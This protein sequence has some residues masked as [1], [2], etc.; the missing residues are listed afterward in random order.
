MFSNIPTVADQNFHKNT[1]VLYILSPRVI[2]E[3]VIRPYAYNFNENLIE[4]LKDQGELKQFFGPRSRGANKE[5]T[6]RAI[7]PSVQGT[8]VDTKDLSMMW[9]FILVLDVGATSSSK[10]A[11]PSSKSR[12][13][14]T[15]FFSEEPLNPMTINNTTPT[16]NPRSIMHFTHHSVVALQDTIQPRYGNRTNMKISHDDD[17]VNSMLGNIASSDL[18]LMTPS[19]IRECS[20][21]NNSDG[22]FISAYGDKHVGALTD[23]NVITPSR[24]KSPKH[25]FQD[26]LFALDYAVDYESLQKPESSITSGGYGDPMQEFTDVFD[27][28]LIGDNRFVP[29]L[30]IDINDPIS[31]HQLIHQYPNINILPCKV[32]ATSQWDVR[33]Q[34][35]VTVL[36]SMS[37]MVAS[38]IS[39]LATGSGISKISFRYN[40]SIGSSLDPNGG[41]AWEIQHV[42]TLVPCDDIGT[43]GCFNTFKN[44]LQLDLWPILRSVAGEFDIMLSHDITGETL[45][46]LQFLDMPVSHGMFE[47]CNRMGGMVAPTIGDLST[48]SHNTNELQSLV[49]S[50]AINAG[51]GGY[52]QTNNSYQPTKEVTS[53]WTNESTVNY[54][55]EESFTV[56]SVIDSDFFK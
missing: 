29:Q 22:E 32:P 7:L 9:S 46:G 45:V 12:I 13:L 6:H 52:F 36:N 28:S 56:S 16:I 47:T 14:C 18:Y 35:D 39:T 26:I 51:I 34:D 3:Q 21:G 20:R 19:D 33:P 50:M 24:L 15:G 53:T 38:T 42:E 41:G 23:K 31:M 11:L 25:Q 30:G 55:Q 40:S 1:C 44:L 54:K 49:D 43:K 8:R 27:A 17:C 48:F 37:S 2:P 5:S 4:D 10:Y